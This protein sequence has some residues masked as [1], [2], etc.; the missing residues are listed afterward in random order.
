VAER[1]VVG[2]GRLVFPRHSYRL[3][4]FKNLS[5]LRK[6]EVDCKDSR[7]FDKSDM[8]TEEQAAT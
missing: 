3:E 6:T 4:C 7:G 1:G 8:P 5:A 2:P